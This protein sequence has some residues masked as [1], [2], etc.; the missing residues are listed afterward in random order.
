MLRNE[1][2]NELN[3]LKEKSDINCIKDQP[4]MEMIRLGAT[5]DGLDQK[6]MFYA[7]VVLN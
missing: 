5:T 1:M 6:Q 3:A 4:Q 2:G 7:I